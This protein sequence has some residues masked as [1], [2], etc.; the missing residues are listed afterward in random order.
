MLIW[1]GV[2]ILFFSF[3][4]TKMQGYI[5]FTSPSLFIVTSFFYYKLK[6]YKCKYKISFLLQKLILLLIII[7]PIRYSIERIKPL[8]FFKRQPEWVVDLKK[9]ND[10]YNG[11]T[12]LFNYDK[13]IEAMFYTNFIVYSYIPD[14]NKIKEL[15]ASGYNVLI[16]EKN[17]IPSEIRNIMGIEFI[18]ENLEQKTVNNFLVYSKDSLRNNKNNSDT[19]L[20][21]AV[22]DLMCHLK[23][24]SVSRVQGGYDFFPLF[25]YVEPYIGKA[26]IAIGNL[27]T[28]LAGKEKGFSGF[29]LFNSPDEFCE[30]AAK[31][32][33]NVLTTANNHCIDKGIKGLERTIDIINQ[34]G[35]YQTGTFKTEEESRDVLIL[36]AKGIKV[37]ILAYTY[38]VNGLSIPKDKKYSVNLINYEK[39]ESDIEEAKS[40]NADKIIV[41]IHWGEEYQ[42]FPNKY[43]KAIA[44]KIFSAGADIILGS[45]PHVLQGTDMP[46]YE[47]VNGKAK[48]KFI[49]YSMGN[50]IANQFDAH[51]RSGVILYIKLIKNHNTNE[52]EI[53]KVSFEPTYIAK[54]SLVVL[55]VSEA[56]EVIE[57]KD[58]N[59]GIYRFKGYLGNLKAIY[60]ETKRHLE[61]EDYNIFIEE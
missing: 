42:R 1:F 8:E 11:K 56:I 20:I 57:Q 45:H 22:G 7:L 29:P 37:A 24:A 58:I 27:E 15:I 35:I 5:L 61:K 47:D 55:P 44:D 46:E 17:D 48:K 18:G 40:R 36:N 54:G 31:C 26:D 38:G 34:N 3:V 16:K 59:S 6:E 30:A 43:Q 39:I 13:P 32:G 60:Q 33:F 51:T 53:S 4:Q 52:T 50:F 28:V 23:E 2:P 19:I 25:E 9:I 21:A 10:K 41:S 14:T 49:I 12:V